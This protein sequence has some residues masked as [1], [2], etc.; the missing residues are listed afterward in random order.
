METE[1]FVI[2]D[3]LKKYEFKNAIGEVFGTLIFNPSDASILE[4]YEAVIDEINNVRK[5][6]TNVKGAEKMIEASRAFKKGLQ[7]ILNRDIEA[8][9]FS[10]YSPVTLMGEG[11]FYGEIILEKIGN[12]IEKETGKRVDKKLEKIKKY[13]KKYSD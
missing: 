6:T 5:D 13:T 7:K 9:L 11:D 3:G 2:D 1:T 12:A 4:R 8:D 10:V